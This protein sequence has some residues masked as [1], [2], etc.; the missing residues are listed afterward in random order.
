MKRKD[1]RKSFSKIAPAYDCFLLLLLDRAGLI[2]SVVGFHSLSCLLLRLPFLPPPKKNNI[3]FTF[4]VIFPI[5]IF[6]SP[7]SRAS[8][9]EKITDPPLLI[10]V[11]PYFV[12]SFLSWPTGME[13]SRIVAL[14]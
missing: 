11:Y 14:V 6:F 3:R 7:P 12:R 4:L 1:S 13:R 2:E 5:S 9:F 8:S 10:S